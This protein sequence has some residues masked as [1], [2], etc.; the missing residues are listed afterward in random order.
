MLKTAQDLVAAAKE[1]VSGISCTDYKKL[2]D[3]GEP[4]S[5]IDVREKDE[6]DAG[7][8]DE[9]VHIPRGFLEFKIEELIPK[10]DAMIIVQCASGGRAALCGKALQEMGYTNVRNL[11]G[12]Y[13]AY[14]EENKD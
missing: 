7:H 4:Y 14:C 8:I 6:W 13:K 11:E 3:S 1:A 9:A 12:G 5:L 10:K 2:L